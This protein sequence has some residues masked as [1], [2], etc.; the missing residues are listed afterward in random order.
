MNDVAVL[1]GPGDFFV[2][3]L[4]LLKVIVLLESRV[5][6]V[7]Q[8]S[9]VVPRFRTLSSSRAHKAYTIWSRLVSLYPPSLS[10]LRAS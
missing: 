4:N 8:P 5:L 1:V 10:A 2:A 6:D 9:S 3:Q 7:V